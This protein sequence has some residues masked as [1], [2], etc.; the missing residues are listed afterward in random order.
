MNHYF[1][2][3][4]PRVIDTVDALFL[5]NV[6]QTYYR[7]G[8]PNPERKPGSLPDA[9]FFVPS[10]HTTAGIFRGQ[11]DD[12]PLVPGIYRGVELAAER[13]GDVALELG[14]LQA[15]RRFRDFCERAERQNPGFPQ[16][17]ADRMCI[18]QHFGVPTPL[19]DWS[20]NVFAAIF[21]AIR[22]IFAKI[23]R[24]EEPRVFVYHVADERLLQSGIPDEESRLRTPAR[25]AFVKAFPIDR[26]IERQRGVFTYHPHP[27]LRAP[28]I[29]AARYV[30]EGNVVL[31]LL[32]LMKGF[33]FTEDY[34]FP[35]YAG[36]AAAVVAQRYL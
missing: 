19:L 18:A 9:V 3:A 25:S 1:E 14:H 26:R 2:L 35:D 24:G 30:L 17:L 15:T 10:P 34:F 16:S 7:P 29:P 21:F 31:R 36:I 33:G 6:E 23:D 27:E 28:K 13:P 12:W 5:L 22:D 20:Q 32:D 11:V 4:E 8:D